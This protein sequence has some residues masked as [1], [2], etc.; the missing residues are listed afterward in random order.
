MSCAGCLAPTNSSQA[1]SEENGE[2]PT[3]KEKGA[4][5]FHLQPLDSYGGPGQN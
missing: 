5:D 3:G 4:T 2:K 1:E